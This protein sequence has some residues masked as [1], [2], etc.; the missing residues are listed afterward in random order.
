MIRRVHVP[1]V[2]VGLVSL[3]EAQNRHM[4]DVLR[5]E[6][7]EPIEVFDDAGRLGL[8]MVVRADPSGVVLEVSQVFQSG[9]KG[10]LTVAS[11]IPKGE[12][13]DWMI[14]KLSE[15]GVDRFIPLNCARSVVLPRGVNKIDRWAR[16]AVE[17][18]KQSRRTGVMRIDP[19]TPLQ[20]LVDSLDSP[21]IFLS[22]QQAPSLHQQLTLRPSE[23][24]TL[25]IGPEGGW[26]PEEM[27]YMSSAGLLP[28]RLTRTILRVET[29]A[30]IAAAIASMRE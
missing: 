24:L 9:K 18:A 23:A 6:A 1:Q 14:E 12:R 20:A 29:A 30:I 19:L 25:L 10:L 11:A 27:A 15:I 2:H 7:G 5:V 3:D 4:R 28:A 22:T 26:T 13:A 17:S 8:A 21:A 16:I